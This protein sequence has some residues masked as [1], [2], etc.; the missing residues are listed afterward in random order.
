M[1]LIN[2]LLFTISIFAASLYGKNSLID[3]AKINPHIQIKGVYIDGVE[4]ISDTGMLYMLQ[5]GVAHAL[6]KAQCYVESKGLGLKIYRVIYLRGSVSPHMQEAINQHI[7]NVSLI[8]LKTSQDLRM[9]NP[10]TDYSEK[11]SDEEL[12]NCKF[13]E[14]IMNKLGFKRSHQKWAFELI[15]ENKDK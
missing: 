1:K 6:D 14:E 10:L 13:L 5:E 2:V 4:K 12:E 3:I 15:D 11:P 8:D 9:P 7:I